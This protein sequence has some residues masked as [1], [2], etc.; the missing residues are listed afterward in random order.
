MLDV[1]AKS[2]GMLPQDSGEDLVNL[3]YEL[4]EILKQ[5]PDRVISSNYETFPEL[6]NSVLYFAKNELYRSDEV[7][8]HIRRYSCLMSKFDQPFPIDFLNLNYADYKRHMNWY[9]ENYF[10]RE[11]GENFYGLKHRKQVIDTFNKAFGMHD[12][13]FPYKLPP[14]PRR[15][16]VIIPNPLTVHKMINYEGYNEDKDVNSLVQ[17]MFA[18]GFWFGLRNPSELAVMKKD[19]IFFDDGYMIVKEPK[20][21]NTIK[22]IFPDKN[23][24]VGK[25][26]KSLKNYV[27]MLLPKFE[28]SKSNGYLFVKPSDGAP[29]NRRYF[30][31][32]QSSYGKMV[33]PSFHPYMTREWCACAKLIQARLKWIKGSFRRC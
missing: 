6:L 19:M 7:L 24:F 8:D 29:F 27:D 26:G 20:K 23:I 30:G 17:Y 3:S 11:T 25:T 22:Q 4:V 21:Y 15:K 18:F 12:G 2:I 32:L 14:R 31:K 28:T 9:K 1:E 33:Y 5:N 16:V 10:N 13:W